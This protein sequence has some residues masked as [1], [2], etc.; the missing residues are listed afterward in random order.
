MKKPE[1]CPDLRKEGTDKGDAA[2][3]AIATHIDLTCPSY[4][5]LR[6]EEG[7]L[8]QSSKSFASHCDDAR[9]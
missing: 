2:T 7:M 3:T 5:T 9:D 1:S 8:L 6:E 4:M